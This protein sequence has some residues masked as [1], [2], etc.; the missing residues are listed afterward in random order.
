M[1]RKEGFSTKCW[2]RHC[3]VVYCKAVGSWGL[4]MPNEAD[5]SVFLLCLAFWCKWQTFRVR[6]GMANIDWKLLCHFQRALTYLRP[7]AVQRLHVSD[8]Q[9]TTTPSLKKSPWNMQECPGSPRGVANKEFNSNLQTEN[10]NNC[11]V[12][13]CKSVHV[14]VWVFACTLT[15]AWVC[16]L[17]VWKC[18]IGDC[19]HLII[20]QYLLNSFGH[21]ELP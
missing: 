6:P 13:V 2:H 8:W 10:C 16:V 11:F 15:N 20:F 4:C 17:R 5:F 19:S 14:C 21:P 18:H 1:L 12:S 9:K 3:N 7:M